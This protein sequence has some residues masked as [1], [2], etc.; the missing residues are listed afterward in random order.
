MWGHFQFGGIF[1]RAR[2]ARIWQSA[3][4]KDFAHAADVK[5]RE[6]M[7]ERWENEQS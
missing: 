2:P 3:S 6:T 4:K 5:A 7:Q 1:L